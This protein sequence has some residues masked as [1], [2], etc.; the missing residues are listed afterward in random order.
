[1]ASVV[2]SIATQRSPRCWA[3]VRRR[4]HRQEE[5]KN[6]AED[7]VVAVGAQLE[8]PRDVER[9]RR[10]RTLTVPRM[11]VASG[12]SLEP[13]TAT[14]ADAAGEDRGEEGEVETRHDGTTSGRGRRR[15]DEGRDDGARR[16]GGGRGRFPLLP[17]PAQ[18][19]SSERRSVSSDENSCRMWLMTIPMTKMPT[20]RSRRT[21]ASTRNGI[22]SMRSWPKMKIPFSRIR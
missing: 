14:G 19:F 22:A 8:I 18:S 21:P 13:D 6:R 20:K 10:K 16:A 12:S 5:E 15:G 7:A 3:S 4:R 2:A 9:D 1:M 17:P 11:T